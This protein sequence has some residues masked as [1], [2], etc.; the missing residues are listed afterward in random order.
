VA[1][2]T[3]QG[4]IRRVISVHIWRALG[5]D[6]QDTVEWSRG[7]EWVAHVDSLGALAVLAEMPNEF[8][9]SDDT[10]EVN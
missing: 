10:E 2:V 5:V 8:S 4:H 3:F 1:E 7:N 6:D 9:I